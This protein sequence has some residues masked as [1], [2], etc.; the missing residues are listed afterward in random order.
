MIKTTYKYYNTDNY[1]VL[2]QYTLFDSSY[3]IHF[4][5][6]SSPVQTC[7]NKRTLFDRMSKFVSPILLKS[8]KRLVADFERAQPPFFLSFSSFHLFGILDILFT[9]ISDS[10][11]SLTKPS[12]INVFID[13]AFQITIGIYQQS[14]YA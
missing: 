1:L 14:K 5:C 11:S 4:E 12:C 13:I 3:F 8:P 7:A 10:I 9:F 6:G 2:N